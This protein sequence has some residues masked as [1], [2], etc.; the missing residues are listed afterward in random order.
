METETVGEKTEEG[1]GMV[2]IEERE[3]KGNGGRKSEI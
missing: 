2:R 3:E 1:G